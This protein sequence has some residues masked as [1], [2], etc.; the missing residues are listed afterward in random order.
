MY[1]RILVPL[2]GSSLAENALEQAKDLC[3]RVSEIVLLQVIHMPMPIMTPDISMSLLTI[4]S[5]ALRAEALSYLQNVADRLTAEG[6]QVSIDVVEADRIADAIVDYAK[7]HTIDL[8]VQST[9]GRGGFSRLV[10]GSVS[11]G[12]LRKTP[13]PVMFVRS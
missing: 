10:F 4:D 9:H 12:V 7:E 3:A 8:I 11:E 2:D 1:K 6:L 5:E 13:C